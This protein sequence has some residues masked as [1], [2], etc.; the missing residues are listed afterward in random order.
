MIE[1]HY[2]DTIL[3]GKGEMEAIINVQQLIAMTPAFHSN[4]LA[5]KIKK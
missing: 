4:A 5:R 3:Q 2:N 1:H